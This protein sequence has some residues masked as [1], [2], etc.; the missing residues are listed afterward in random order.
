VASPSPAAIAW[1][2]ARSPDWTQSDAALA[3]SLNATTV[4]NPVTV[5]P[6]VPRP[7]AASDLTGLLDAAATAKV[8]GR[9]AIVA[10]R[11]DIDR[12]SRVACGNWIALAEAAGDVTASQYTAMIAVLQATHA[13]PSWSA[14]VPAP[15]D[16]LGRLL[17]PQD[18]AASRPGE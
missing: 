11:D 15:L 14:Q 18:I 10:F 4:A 5:A 3:D 2:R 7:F 12:Q 6:Q 9:P 17:D 1:I 13:D 16:A 8:Y